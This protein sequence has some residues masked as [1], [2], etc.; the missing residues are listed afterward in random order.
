M[1]N[2]LLEKMRRDWDR[3]ARENAP[4]Y[5][6]TGS[7]EWESDA[8]FQTG[9]KNV[10]EHI[11]ND[12]ENICQ[13]LEPKAM[14]V[15][16]LG[17]GVGRMTRALAGYFGHVH[18]VDVSDVMIRL[19]R[20]NLAEFTNVSFHLNNRARLASIADA[21]VDFAFSYLVFQHI[22]ARE[23]MES[24]LLETARMLA[25]GRLFKLQVQGSTEIEGGRD[26]SDTWLGA[27]VSKQQAF[28]MA[29]R[30]GF[31]LRYDVGEG[32]AEYWLWMFKKSRF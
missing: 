22:P 28:D 3:R 12:T 10:A 24:V 31:E 11:F 1:T 25:G 4:Y 7:Q 2:S 20:G 14:T 32:Q 26:P 17:C 16:E 5:V 9:E 6:H 29:N 18:A 19:A 21:S 13:G 30:S 23:I 27:S 15:L 8:F